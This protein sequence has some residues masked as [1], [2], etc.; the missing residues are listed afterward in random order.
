MSVSPWPRALQVATCA[1]IVAASFGPNAARAQQEQA[2][3]VL[4]PRPESEWTPEERAIRACL[5]YWGDEGSTARPYEGVGYACGW[6]AK[7]GPDFRM[8]HG[9]DG[10]PIPRDVVVIKSPGTVTMGSTFL[11]AAVL[12]G[13]PKYLKRAVEVGQ[14]LLVGQTSAGGWG[15]ELWMGRTEV[16][17]VRTGSGFLNWPREL[18]DGSRGEDT[19]DLD[20]RT[21]SDAMEHLYQLWWITR[22]QRFLDSYQRALQMYLAAQEAAGG[23]FPEQYPADDYRAL[24]SFFG[25][26]SLTAVRDLK[27]AYERTG[28]KE[29]LDAI[30]RCADWIVSVRKPGQGW[31]MRYDRQGHPAG[32]RSFEPP[33]P[34]TEGTLSAML[35]LGVALEYTADPRYYDAIQDAANWLRRLPSPGGV[36]A[37]YYHAE[38]NRPWFVNGV[39]EEVRGPRAARKDYVWVGA[40]GKMG[41]QFARNVAQ[42]ENIEPRQVPEGGDPS[43]GTRLALPSEVPALA[44]KGITVQ[45]VLASQDPKGYWL[46]DVNGS[47]MMT[48]AGNCNRVQ[49]LLGEL[50]RKQ[51]GLKNPTP[52]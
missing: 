31:A 38:N 26:T 8:R 19:A 27:P 44:A 32:G 22:D 40:W 50:I 21:T 41:I 17:T 13:E 48:V 52:P 16:N 3:L 11:Q 12:L 9:H 34:S 24:A 29:Y 45:Q 4:A 5:D 1:L 7:V 39:G 35:T 20:D 14:L 10:Q 46:E 51:G 6:K 43:F 2:P 18:A 47:R 42:Q 33:G 25:Y 30:V 15:K 28:R 36:H 49:M 23:G 37:R